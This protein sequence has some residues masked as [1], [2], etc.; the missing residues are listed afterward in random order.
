LAPEQFS[1]NVSAKTDIYALGVT[2]YEMLSGGKL[3]YHGD[4]SSPGTTT[5][6]KYEWEH[7]NLSLP[8]LGQFN[9]SLPQSISDIVGRAL[10]K[11]PR[12]RFDSALAFSEA[13]DRAQSAAPSVANF[14][15][16]PEGAT[17]LEPRP[18]MKSEAIRPASPMLPPQPRVPAR[19]ITAVRAG[20]PYLYVRAGEMSGQ[21]VPLISQGL[22]IG[23]GAGCNVQ[24]HERSVSRNHAVIFATKRGI[25]VRD[26][27][28]GLGTLL[29]GKRIPPNAPMPLHQGDVIQI[30]YYQVFEL[31]IR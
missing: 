28:S 3:P 21:S 22:K 10:Q 17:L 13:F 30:G 18:P 8:P 15:P 23:R 19:P 6:A 16:P 25:Y 9:H 26:E 24:L 27:G 31:R 11:E 2:V 1:H 14:A 20:G 7:N 4:S 5:R 12:L 29:N